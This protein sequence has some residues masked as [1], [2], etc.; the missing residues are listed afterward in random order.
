MRAR[1]GQQRHQWADAAGLQRQPDV[2]QR[3]PAGQPVLAA[4]RA[5]VQLD[6]LGT[7]LEPHLWCGGG[8][9][10]EDTAHVLTRESE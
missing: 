7:H 4:A 9:E 8:R 5:R 6:L 2:Q 1:A 3:L 10:R